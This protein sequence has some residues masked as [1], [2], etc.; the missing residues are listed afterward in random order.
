[1]LTE[2]VSEDHFRAA[3]HIDYSNCHLICCIA[4]HKALTI[5]LASLLIA[6][7]LPYVIRIYGVTIKY[8]CAHEMLICRVN[9]K[10]NKMH[11][12]EASRNSDGVLPFPPPPYPFV[13]PLH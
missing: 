6:V 9:V 11:L 2:I 7:I 13:L 5:S 1:M 3:L 8:L 10:L 12:P 4:I